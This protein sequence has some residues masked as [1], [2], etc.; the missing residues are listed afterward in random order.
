M[1]LLALA[2]VF[3]LYSVFGVREDNDDIFW[4]TL[5]AILG[6]GVAFTTLVNVFVGA[7]FAIIF[8]ALYIIITLILLAKVSLEYDTNV[9]TIKYYKREA[10]R[11][12]VRF[13]REHW[14]NIVL[15]KYKERIRWIT[16]MQE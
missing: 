15:G 7:I 16:T 11:E 14:Q 4:P 5:F 12:L 3:L 13:Y 10:E 1:W 8:A 6:Y 2:I 9:L